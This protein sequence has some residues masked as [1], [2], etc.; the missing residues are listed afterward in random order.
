MVIS[1]G[2]RA[3]R[4]EVVSA[5]SSQGVR[6]VWITERDNALRA[7]VKPDGSLTIESWTNN[8]WRPAVINIQAQ[9]LDDED[10]SGDDAF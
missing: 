9:E 4:S 6:D 2:S 10:D 5:Y 7:R 1:G 8:E 3:N